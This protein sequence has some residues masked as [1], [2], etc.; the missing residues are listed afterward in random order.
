[1]GTSARRNCSKRISVTSIDGIPNLTHSYPS[2][3]SERGFKRKRPITQ[4]KRDGHWVRCMAFRLRSKAQ[5]TL[6][7][8]CAKPEREF[9][10]V[11][12][13]RRM[14]HWF[15]DSKLQAP[16]F[17]ET[18]RF[19]NSSWRGRRT[20][21]STERQ[22]VHTMSNGHLAVPAAGKRRRSLHTVRPEESAAMA[23]D[24][25]AFLHTSAESA[26]SNPL[27]EGFPQ[28]GT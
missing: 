10:A 11:T 6:R 19:R 2:M 28:R 1:M 17:W 26:D 3:N 9:A 16:S 5:S 27:Q 13:L 18:R 7:V 23:A 14:R 25:S 21:R 20:A 8:C 4:S 15:R 22:T 12:L 24:R